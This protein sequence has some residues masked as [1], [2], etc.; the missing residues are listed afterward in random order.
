MLRRTGDEYLRI[1]EDRV[2]DEKARLGMEKS[3][4]RGGDAVAPPPK[5][6]E[7]G[8]GRKKD[9][10]CLAGFTRS[11]SR[12]TRATGR[13]ERQR[14]RRVKT[15]GGGAGGLSGDGGGS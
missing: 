8:D 2:R 5:G 7:A 6:E 3:L 11:G 12:R 13:G 14:S 1:E 9:V 10:L 15:R 4:R